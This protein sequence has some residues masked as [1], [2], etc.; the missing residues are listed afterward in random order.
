[1]LE[2]RLEL[3][4]TFKCNNNCL[5]CIE[6]ENRLRYK[7]KQIFKD[8]QDIFAQLSKY[9]K[10]GY[11]HLNLLGGEPF[12]DKNITKIL[13]IAKKLNFK[14][15]LATNGSLLANEKI[16]A[17]TLPLID[18]LIISIHGHNNDLVTKLSQN[19]QLYQ[20]LL[21]GLANTRKYFKG[22]LLKVNCVIN[23]FN[24]KYLLEI[25]KFI[26]LHGVNEVN[27]TSLDITDYNKDLAINFVKLKPLI[28][29]LVEFS[30]S[31]DMILRFSDIPLCILGDYFYLSNHLFFDQRDK[32]YLE[33]D[34]EENVERN[35]I[36]PKICKKCSK[37]EICQGLDFKYHKILGDKA[38][39]PF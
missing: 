32:Y 6:K 30:K 3:Y 15:A 16:A 38:L 39:K 1:M 11:S 20:N 24:Y 33:G 25:L 31:Q 13:T 8:D 28:K 23:K 36:K 2:K 26:K 17:E 14:I 4:I 5:F 27:L 21:S 29:Q 35:K 10:N 12:L 22:R 34:K 18:D 9:R 7:N 19:K 37:Q